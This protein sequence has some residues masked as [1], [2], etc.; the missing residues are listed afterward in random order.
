MKRTVWVL[1]GMVATVLVFSSSGLAQD[2]VNRFGLGF[3][4]S[5]LTPE[6]DTVE[7]IKYDPDSTYLIEGNLTYFFLKSFSLE[8]LAGYT[9]PDV[10]AEFSG[11][12]VD[13][14]EL[15][16]IP[17]LLTGQ[18]HYWFNQKSNVYLGGGVGYYLNDFS[19]S[20]TVTSVDPTLDIEADN[21][22]GYHLNAGFETFVANN[23]TINFDLKYIF[24]EVD[25]T[26]KEPGFPDDTSTVGLDSFVIGVGVK[27]YF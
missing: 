16:Q 15:R 20:S 25:F 3:R 26:E 6:S 14:G 1:L 7:D 21:S 18:Y 13:F 5:Y 17:I 10:N 24:N 9:K 23:T 4:A 8:F 27:Y 19:L 2:V 11:L 22:I 12:S